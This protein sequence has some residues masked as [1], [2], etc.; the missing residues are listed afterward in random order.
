M[1]IVLLLIIVIPIL[2]FWQFNYN[3]L[4]DN[5]KESSAKIIEAKLANISLHIE[6]VMDNII[7]FV[8]ENYSGI[9]SE[10]LIKN[11]IDSTGAERSLQ[12]SKLTLYAFTSAVKNRFIDSIYFLVEGNDEIITTIHNQKE[13]PVSSELGVAINKEFYPMHANGKSG[14]IPVK[15]PQNQDSSISYVKSLTVI[16]NNG[17]SRI[18]SIA[19]NLYTDTFNK[20]FDMKDFSDSSIIISDYSGTAML[21]TNESLI[22]TSLKQYSLYEEAY[23]SNKTIG[24]Y[25]V[26]QNDVDYMIVYYT[27]L[28]TNSKYIE[29]VPISTLYGS[30]DIHSKMLVIILFIGI[31]IALFGSYALVRYV[32]MPIDNLIKGMDELAVGNLVD[33]KETDRNDELGL[34]LKGYNVTV[35]KLRKLID[36]VYVQK[37]LRREAQLIMFQSQMDEH[38][39]YN[40]L[41]SIY[42]TAT[43]EKAIQTAD[44]VYMLSRFFRFS[45]AKGKVMI[46]VGEVEQTIKLYLSIQKI[47]FNDRLDYHIHVDNG[48]KNVLVNKYI[49]QPIVENAIIHGIEGKKGK[50]HVDISFKY[51]DDFLYFQVTDNGVGMS[52]DKLQKLLGHINNYN[53]V[54]GENFALKNI[55]E[56]IRIMYGEEYKITITSE[57]DKGTTVS[58]KI[59][60]K[61][62][63]S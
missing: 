36:E 24:T 51:D 28:A 59:P 46:T 47:R 53:M 14:W 10:T 62:R 52:T 12:R 23:K 61:S 19:I 16:D 58:F 41:N 63:P 29:V 18:C 50:G 22:N 9:E 35:K 2:T 40:T 20:I 25:Y 57:I 55:S 11:Y 26:T 6:Y 17:N 4:L 44:M 13:I 21:G 27:S 3:A 32:T 33:A 60:A 34:M 54:E 31:G 8:Y 48:A 49:F 39:L 43:K 1:P 30:V 37:L 42:C 5:V 7:D 56:Q 45:L 38:F 15:L